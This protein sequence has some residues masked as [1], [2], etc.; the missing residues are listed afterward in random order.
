M[1]SVNLLS[2]IFSYTLLISTHT[3]HKVHYIIVLMILDILNN[4]RC[5]L[6]FDE[7]SKSKQ[8][9]GANELSV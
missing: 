6:A 9:L 2:F 5:N 7:V 1:K 8:D 4:F 3:L